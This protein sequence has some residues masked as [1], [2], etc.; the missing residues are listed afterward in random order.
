MVTVCK[1]MF[2]VKTACVVCVQ[3]FADNV[4][5]YGRWLIPLSVAISCYGGLNS[6]IIA[7]SR[8]VMIESG[9]QQTLA[10]EECFLIRA[11]AQSVY[12]ALIILGK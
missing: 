12:N 6:S 11:V 2:G 4:L 8:S 5:G 9:L 10:V 3:T 7:A 1:L